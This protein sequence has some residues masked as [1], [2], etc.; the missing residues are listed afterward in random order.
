MMATQPWLVKYGSLNDISV[1]NHFTAGEFAAG[2]GR[3]GC[4][5]KTFLQDRLKRLNKQSIVCDKTPNIQR[6]VQ[7]HIFLP[8]AP[9]PITFS[10]QRQIPWTENKSLSKLENFVRFIS[11]CQISMQETNEVCSMIQIR[12]RAIYSAHW[13]LLINVWHGVPRSHKESSC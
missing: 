10:S 13:L 4:C 5:T 8:V 12:R 2:G 9:G 6:A 3:Q 11:H 1:L 7:V